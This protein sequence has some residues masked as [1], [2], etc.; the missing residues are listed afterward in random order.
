MI[1]WFK[2]VKFLIL[3]V[4][5]GL[6]IYYTNWQTCLGVV[7]LIWANNLDMIKDKDNE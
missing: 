7:L 4:A 1:E 5:F 3:F 6:V 2:V